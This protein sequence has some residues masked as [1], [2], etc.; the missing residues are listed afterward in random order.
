MRQ[1]IS[2]ILLLAVVMAP[3]AAAQT[4]RRSVP[5]LRPTQ[6]EPQEN[7][8]PPRPPEALVYVQ[9]TIDL[10]AQLGNEENLMTLDGEPLPSMLT[11]SVT[12]GLVIDDSGHVVTRLVGVTFTNPPREIKVT[13][14]RGIPR[15]AQFIGFD[16]ATGLCVLQVEGQGIT[17]PAN[18]ANEATQSQ[19]AVRL[20][21]F[22][23]ALVQSQS[24]LMGFSRPRIHSFTG[25]V[26]RAVGDFRYQ[27]SHPLYRLMTPQLT[28]IQDGSL[29]VDG[30]GAIFGIAVHDLTEEGYNLVY[31][32]G[33][34]RTIAA[35]VLGARGSLA[36]GWLGATGVTL[37]ISATT[38]QKT[39]PIDLGVRV[40]G[41][42]PDS[43]A[44]QAGIQP[45]DVLLAIND[46]SI[47][48]VEQLSS[49]LRQLSADSE[50]T[51]RVKRGREYKRLQAKLAPAPALES[52]QQ[53]TVF[54][55]QLRS[56]EEKLQALPPA[57]PER[58]QI[59][60]KVTAMRAI[61]DNIL[62]PAPV[63]V[64]LRV[65]FGIETQPLT[66]QL[67]RYFAVP[68]GALV[69]A[70]AEGSPAARAGL[71]AGDV[72]IAVGKN[73]IADSSSLLRAIDELG[74]GQVTLTIA[75][76]R[77]QMQV[78]LPR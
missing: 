77:E 12:L 52:G 38:R 48:S 21:G 47:A 58:R 16:A 75:R 64:K 61:M 3:L 23:S 29:V 59:E 10:S 50:V 33:R 1:S 53:I 65:R 42:L 20:F 54:A 34:V 35:A 72:I 45:H 39:T 5:V 76:Q 78:V 37:T 9:Q 56:W 18:V 41:V 7:P 55:G 73:A 11:K 49:T 15:N 44:E 63:E 30:S 22:N 32:M 51:L 8:V 17:A 46:R 62:G 68:G 25:R 40:T 70:I 43:P 36:H 2:F 26:S 66:T 27:S 71:R 24:P 67:M 69:T 74:D 31:S 14:Q 13:P 6:P 60:P 19:L 28:A 57:A 4:P